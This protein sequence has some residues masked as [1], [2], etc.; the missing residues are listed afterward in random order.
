MAKG[1]WSKAMSNARLAYQAAP[2]GEDVVPTLAG[3]R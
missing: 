1:S 3:R 2:A